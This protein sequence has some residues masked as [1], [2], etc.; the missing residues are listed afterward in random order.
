MSD[1]TLRLKSYNGIEKKIVLPSEIGKAKVSV[2]GMLALSPVNIKKSDECYL[3]RNSI[4]EIVVSEGITT[5]ETGA[6]KGCSE[7]RKVTL[8]KSLISIES[9]A[10]RECKKLEMVCFNGENNTDGSDAEEADGLKSIDGSAFWGC[11]ALKEIKIP[12]TVKTIGNYAFYCCSKLTNIVFPE[13]L[14]ELGSFA[15]YGTAYTLPFWNC[16]KLT[17]YTS[18]GSVAEQYAKDHGIPVV[19]DA[20]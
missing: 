2:V 12:N 15:F 8:P 13:T 5:I 10:F 11:D 7:L 17:I 18:A 6:F 19:T 3:T 4:E 20:K 14:E 9:D 1:G 16:E